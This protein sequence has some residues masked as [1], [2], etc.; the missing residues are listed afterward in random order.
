[1]KAERL[2]GE[3][4]THIAFGRGCVTRTQ[5]DDYIVADF[6]GTERMFEFPSAFSRYLTADN[7]QLRPFLPV[8]TPAPARK[9]EEP[10]RRGRPVMK[11]KKAG[12]SEGFIRDE[13]DTYIL[14]DMVGC[15]I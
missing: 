8:C 3:K 1:M 2:V 10:H 11:K 4:I 14:A 9:E 15:T 6:G 12:G 5:G 13:Y 7:E